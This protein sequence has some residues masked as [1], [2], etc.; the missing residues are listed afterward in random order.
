MSFIEY[1][2]HGGY[3]TEYGSSFFFGR[4]QFITILHP[5][6]TLKIGSEY[7]I[8]YAIRLLYKSYNFLLIRFTYA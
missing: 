1:F 6:D 7:K 2:E 8:H 4:T 3:I 5:H